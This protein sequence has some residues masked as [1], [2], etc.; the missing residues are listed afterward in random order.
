MTS[1][2]LTVALLMLL[3]IAPRPAF[4]WRSLLPSFSSSPFSKEDAHVKAANA[5]YAAGKYDDALRGYE[6]ALR[7]HPNAPELQFDRGNALFKMGREAEAREAYLSALGGKD[8]TLKS[9]D[10]FNMGNS[11]WSL[12]KTEDAAEAYQRALTIDPN[13]EEARHNLELLLAPPPDAGQPDGGGHDGG[14]DGGGDGGQ[15]QS[16]GDGGQSDGGQGQDGGSKQPQPADAGSSDGGQNQDQRDGGGEPP[17][18][19]R[20]D[21]GASPKPEPLD[22]LKSEQLLDALRQREKNLQMWKFRQKQQK[23]QQAEKDW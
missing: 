14:S 7:E 15:S 3:P 22:K 23:T 10:Y 16:H 8:S 13:F 12:D 17:P 4:A 5:A 9:Q 6:D 21:A 18:Q 20:G 1:P 19:P 2:R 11:L